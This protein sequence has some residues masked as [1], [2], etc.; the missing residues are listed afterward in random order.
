MTCV[1]ES[2][3]KKRTILNIFI[4]RVEIDTANSYPFLL[5]SSVIQAV[6]YSTL[7]QKIT[8]ALIRTEIDYADVVAFIPDN[9]E[10]TN[11]HMIH[12]FNSLLKPL[13]NNC[14]LI[15]PLTDLVTQIQ[16][17]WRMEL[18]RVDYLNTLIKEFFERSHQNS[19][20]F[21]DHIQRHNLQPTQITNSASWF[22][23][24]KFVVDNYEN[25]IEFFNKLADKSNSLARK[26]FSLMRDEMVREQI[27]FVSFNSF[28]F[29]QILENPDLTVTKIYDFFVILKSYVNEQTEHFKP[30]E[31]EFS[32]RLFNSARQKIENYEKHET[33]SSVIRFYKSAK[34]F[35]PFY[36]KSAQIQLSEIMAEFSELQGAQKEWSVYLNICQQL[37]SEVNLFNFWLENRNTL[38]QLFE[39]VKW[40][41]A[42]PPNTV[43]HTVLKKIG[44]ADLNEQYLNSIN[45]ICYNS[46]LIK[47][48]NDYLAKIENELGTE[49]DHLSENAELSSE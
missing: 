28:N 3:E 37:R 15:L 7:G 18:D 34:I 38:P 14:R 46:N 35:D 20:E 42:L 22:N 4:C 16:D 31:T 33:Y 29:R 24:V 5:D 30:K 40:V 49:M 8:K 47:Q 32:F 48:E 13:M 41:L 23:S 45:F 9:N 2:D 17:S 21:T 27:E 11:E 25:L 1:L 6:N 43:D 44:K 26:I 39:T 36:V 10:Q 12:A 19:L